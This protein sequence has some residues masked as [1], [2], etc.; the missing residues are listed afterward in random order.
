[1]AGGT[2]RGLRR[3]IS[4][5]NRSANADAAE[6][7]QYEFQLTDALDTVDSSAEDHRKTVAEVGEYMKHKKK[8]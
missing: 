4:G 3:D 5:E 6:A 1:M 7:K 2:C 8:K